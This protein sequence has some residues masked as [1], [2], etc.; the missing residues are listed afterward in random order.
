MTQWRVRA[1]LLSLLAGMVMAPGMAWA[2]PVKG[3]PPSPS[4]PFVSGVAAQ[5]RIVPSGG[6]VHV[7]APVGT[8]GL[9]IVG[10]LSV[11]AGDWVEAGQILAI[12]RDQPLLQAQLDAANLE[13]NSAA[14]GLAEAQ[15]AQTRA[16]AEVQAQLADLEGRAL[17]AEANVRRAVESTGLA[18]DQV[19]REAA[20][21]QAALMTAQHLQPTAKAAADAAVAQAQAGLDAITRL[22]TTEHAMASAQLDQAK[23]AQQRASLD[24]A[25]QVEQMQAQADLA[26]LRVK[27][28][29]AALVQEPAPADHAQWAPVQLEA[30]AARA[31]VEAENKLL[32]A[33]EAERAA[34]VATA[35]ARLASAEA[36]AVVAHAQLTLSEVHAPSAGRV[37]AVHTHAG[38]AVGPAGILELG[39][40]R[41]MFVDA[42]VFIDDIPGV[43]TGQKTTVL[44]SALPD[45]GLTGT[46]VEISPMVA[47]NTLPNI[48]PT[49]FSDQPVI[50]VKVHLDTPGPAA[51][52]INSQVTVRFAQ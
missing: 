41:D 29:E 8:Q 36:A 23:A 15:A 43:H 22:R 47:G 20:A 35:Q 11:K 51:N 40:T 46:V 48:D 33:I 27:Q 31:A 16:V 17:S 14:A 34:D 42:L 12:M 38:E 45:E 21:A 39:D 30:Q 18:L 6:I 13:K 1:W 2:Q 3:H 9:P 32:S 5:G 37:L 10:Q 50:L 44:G 24:A 7:A 28:A 49:V 25:G 4:N 26:D 52:I 19:K